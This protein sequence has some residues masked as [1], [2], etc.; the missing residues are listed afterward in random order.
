MR[1]E[2]FPS[3]KEARDRVSSFVLDHKSD[4]YPN[5]PLH[6]AFTGD[7]GIGDDFVNTD[8][9]NISQRLGFAY[10]VFG[11]GRTAIRSGGGIYYSHVIM[12]V[13]MWN[14]EQ[15]PWQPSISRNRTTATALS[16]SNPF[17][18]ANASPLLVGEAN[19]YNYGTARRGCR[20]SSA[21]IQSSARLTPRS[22]I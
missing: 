12:N 13:K 5:A 3:A 2:L 11:D 6:I 15:P 19:Q 21:T 17:G 20:T 14:A 16:L 7:K 8:W 18:V 1:Y 10:D 9:N 4:Q 22:G